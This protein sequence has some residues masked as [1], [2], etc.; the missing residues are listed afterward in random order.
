M[1]ERTRL[2]YGVAAENL[3]STTVLDYEEELV[4]DGRPPT[5]SYRKVIT[6]GVAVDLSSLA[7]WLPPDR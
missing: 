5:K 3:E 4:D 1:N 6:Y 7:D 2:V